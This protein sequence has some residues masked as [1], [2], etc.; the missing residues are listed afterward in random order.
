MGFSKTEKNIENGPKN[1]PMVNGNGKKLQ[2]L[3]YKCSCLSFKAN[4]FA[5][6]WYTFIKWIA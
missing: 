3:K 5:K 1:H 2:S 4:K 6:V